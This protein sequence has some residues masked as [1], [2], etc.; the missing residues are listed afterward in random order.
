LASSFFFI[1][2]NLFLMPFY[3]KYS[4]ELRVDSAGLLFSLYPAAGFIVKGAI[5]S[6]DAAKKLIDIGGIVVRVADR[7][8]LEGPNHVKIPLT[9][10]A[11]GYK[12]QCKGDWTGKG[13]LTAFKV[14]VE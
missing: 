6:L 9:L 7:A 4:L 13:E 11:P 14:V 10:F 1:G 5:T 8:W 3:L 12:V 2:G